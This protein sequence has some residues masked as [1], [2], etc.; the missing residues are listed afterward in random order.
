MKLKK[1]N[2]MKFLTKTEVCDMLGYSISRLN[3]LLKNNNIPEHRLSGGNCR[4]LE[5]D[6]I[7][8]MH[9]RKSYKELTKEQREF[10][11]ECSHGI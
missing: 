4:F 5:L 6:I 3:T 10:V 9:Y 7:A 1:G 11:R 2:Y 8:F